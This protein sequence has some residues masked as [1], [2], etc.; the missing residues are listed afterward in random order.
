[1]ARA[2]EGLARDHPRVN[3][4]L[5]ID[6]EAMTGVDADLRGGLLAFLT[7]LGLASGFV[8]LIAC[9]NVTHVMLARML[10]R[11]KEMAVRLALGARGG[12][13]ARQ[14]LTE[15]GV[16]ALL[17]GALGCLLAA[18]A[19]QAGRA[20]LFSIDRRIGLDVRFDATA[21]VVAL[22]VSLLVTVGCGVLPALRGSRTNVAGAL[23]ETSGTIGARSRLWGGF[24]V[25]QVAVSL[26]LLVG[27]GLFLR[28]LGHA[29]TIDPG[30]EPGGVHAVA[31]N[32]A[33]AGVTQDDARRL[34]E[35]QVECIRSATG[36]YR[37]G[38]GP[39]SSPT[40]SP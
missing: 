26:V 31:L 30:F 36:V 24:V 6:V 7:I 8:L 21:L 38:W 33:L 15:A 5:A 28:A 12:R 27:A 22:A 3:R 13:L 18:W 34:L 25:A 20:I 32:P 37:S 40:R 14:L 2:A 1:M 17:S 19:T 11:R 16:L 4:G 35:A 23:K 10:G 9:V 39:G 29:A